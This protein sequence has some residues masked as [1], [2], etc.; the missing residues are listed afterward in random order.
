MRIRLVRSA[1]LV[2]ELF[3]RRILVDPMLDPAGARPPIE[4]TA[5]P[6]RNPTVDL[7]FPAEEVVSGLDAVLVT[8]CHKDHF[9]ETAERLLPH[10]LP[11]FCQPQDAERL[12]VVGARRGTRR[13]RRRSVGS[14]R[15]SPS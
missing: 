3:G 14:R 7:P 10:E 4:Q 8:H 1:T 5:N 6:V 15:A 13:S 9:D 11:V 2:L 12:R